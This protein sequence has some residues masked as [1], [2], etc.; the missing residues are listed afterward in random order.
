MNKPLIVFIAA[1]T[2]VGCGAQDPVN[3]AQASCEVIFADVEAQ[4]LLE[5]VNTDAEGFCTCM[6]DGLKEM[7]ETDQAHSILA[8]NAVAE[9]TQQTG[10]SVEEIARELM[11]PDDTL[12]SDEQSD[13]VKGMNLTERLIDRTGNRFEEGLCP[14]S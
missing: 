6:M 2:L 5:D 9:Q 12:S 8:F 13:I 3:K 11:R 1:F 14:A 7:S 10:R 4:R